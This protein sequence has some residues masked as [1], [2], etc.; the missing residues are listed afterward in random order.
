[1]ATFFKASRTAVWVLAALTAGCGTPPPG[2]RYEPSWNS[3]STHRTPEWFKNAK[4]GIYTTWG[5][6]AVPA[7]RTSYA[8][9]MYEK[10]R[11]TYKY[12]VK[13]YGDPKDFGYKDFIPMFKAEKF[14]PD[15][16]AALFKAAGAQFAGPLAEHHDGF[17][18]WDSALTKWDAADM[19]PKRDV[20]GE[21]AV[22]IRKRDMKFV[23]TFH[24]ITN[25]YWYPHWFTQYD[26]ADPKY[27]GLYGPVHNQKNPPKDWWRDQDRPNREF[28]DLWQGKIVEV[29][30]KYQPDMLWFDFQLDRVPEGR[31]LET[32]AYY[33][34]HADRMGKEVLVTYKRQDL[35]PGV[36]VHD[37]ERKQMLERSNEVWLTDSSLNM[38]GSWGYAPNLDYQSVDTLVDN[39]VDRVSKNGCLLLN[40]GPKSDGTIPQE[41]K[42]RLLGLGKWL[43]LNGEAIYDTT[44]W[45]IYGEGPTKMKAD[46]K[47]GLEEPSRYTG[48]DVRFTAKGNVLYAICLDWPGKEI[49]IASLKRLYPSEISRIEMVGADGDLEWTF[50]R[51][52]GL[53]IKTPENKPCDHAYVFR[54]TRRFEKFK[55]PDSLK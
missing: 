54:I 32:F 46:G 29:I 33:F 20:V 5:V 12:H 15:E 21:L 18:M 14:D 6:Y 22:A 37:L 51:H 16:W 36:G 4:F 24:H 25:W 26:V 53:T 10:Q 9:N 34:N 13:H 2:R 19:G 50:D 8:G 52:K 7:F 1:M 44:A 30:D 48:Q 38:K 23:T 17:A 39:L 40:V 11:D 41:A 47:Y 3:L 42:K 49:T 55:M 43:K 28:L 45:M 31:L 35:A 27:S